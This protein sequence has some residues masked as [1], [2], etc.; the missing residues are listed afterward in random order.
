[1]Y[2]CSCVREHQIHK[3]YTNKHSTITREVVLLGSQSNQW[4]YLMCTADS[5]LVKILSTRDCGPQVT[6][7]TY[8]RPAY[9]QCWL[10]QIHKRIT[11][12]FHLCMQYLHIGGPSQNVDNHCV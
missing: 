6:N 9:T 2:T 4:T 12:V 3:H 8:I 10:V 11:Q 1:M 7:V 5:V